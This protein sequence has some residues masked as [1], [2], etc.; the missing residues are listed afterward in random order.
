LVTLS[1][2]IDYVQSSPIRKI[3]AILAEARKKKDLISFGGG[4]PSLPPPQEVV[5]EI[6]NRIT[7][8]PS[9]SVCYMGTRGISDLLELISQDLKKYGN[10]DV[11]P[12][13][14]LQI[15]VGGTEG[16][17]LS[18]MA[19]TDQGDEVIIADPTY[20]G[21]PEAIKVVNAKPVTLPVYVSEDFQ[22][23]IERLKEVI[24]NRTKG[25][26]LLSPDNPTGRVLNKDVAKAIVDLAVDHDFWIYSD[27]VYKHIIY[28]GE[29]VWVS[30]LPRAREH[31]ITMC[32]MSK[33]VSVPGL[34]TGYMYGP[35]EVIE[36]AE[37][38]KQYVSLCPNTLVQYALMSFYG[39]NVKE[40]Y[41]EKVVSIYKSRRDVML[42]AIRE[43]LP[44]AKTVRPYGAFYVFADMRDYIEPT[45]MGD[46][47]FVMDI[48][49][50]KDVAII[51]GEHFG[52]NGRRHCR[53]T[54]V[55][56]PA[57]R[58]E[59][60]VRRISEYLM[61]NLMEKNVTD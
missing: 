18:L 26:I 24:T 50:T 1:K 25:I 38:L 60:G 45:Q 11:D 40:K 23:D 22:P 9:N 53:F 3:T 56:E 52:K 13:R 47:E 35:P 57:E 6:A 34:R 49:N 27:E 20:L 59:M 37:K 19:T 2:K 51:P 33:E 58:I 61:E 10:I 4:A 48:L 14:E 5:E 44:K 36:A 17:L 42:N 30:A 8:D 16:I 31:V 15:T 12:R 39:G 41:I 28:E 32:S 7:H 46:E 43:Y 55:S 54:F 21:Y 29:H